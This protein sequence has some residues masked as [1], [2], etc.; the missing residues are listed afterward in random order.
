MTFLFFNAADTVLFSRDDA[1]QAEHNH[2]EMGLFALFPFVD[3]KRITEGMRVGYTDDL[4]VFQV[5]RSSRS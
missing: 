2:Q 4:G 5:L 1:E 3:G